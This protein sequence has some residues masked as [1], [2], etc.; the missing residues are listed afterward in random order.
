MKMRYACVRNDPYKVISFPVYFE[1]TSRNE[2]KQVIVAI[3][4]PTE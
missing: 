2:M 1:S 3:W 4:I